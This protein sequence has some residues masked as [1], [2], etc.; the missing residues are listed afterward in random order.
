MVNNKSLT[1][2]YLPLKFLQEKCWV[3]FI[4]KISSRKMFS[5]NSFLLKVDALRFFRKLILIVKLNAVWLY[6]ILCILEFFCYQLSFGES[7]LTIFCCVKKYITNVGNAE[8]FVESF[9]LRC[10]RDDNGQLNLISSFSTGWWRCS[11]NCY[12]LRLITFRDRCNLKI[13]IG[14]D[15]YD[16]ILI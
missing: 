6:T 4:I 1:K 3:L 11:F 5:I 9:N 12:F 10:W 16:L 13:S 14:N 15:N 7:R 2:C 8:N